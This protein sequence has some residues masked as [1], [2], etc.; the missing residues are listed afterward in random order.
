MTWSY[1]QKSMFFMTFRTKLYDQKSKKDQ[2]F[3]TF[4]FKILP[5]HHFLHDQNSLLL[6]FIVSFKHHIHIYSPNTIMYSLSVVFLRISQYNDKSMKIF[7]LQT[8]EKCPWIIARIFVLKKIFSWS[9]FLD[10]WNG[11]N[12]IIFMSL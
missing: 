9:Y 1:D 4:L 2:I 3:T 10:V 6:F 8:V 11:N 5:N 7:F 12:N